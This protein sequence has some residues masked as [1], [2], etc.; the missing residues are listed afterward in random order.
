MNLFVLVWSYLRAKPLNTALNT[1]LL[2]LGIAVVTVLILFGNQLRQRVDANV[3]GIDL[4]VGA[5][6]SPLQLILCSIFH[7]DFP[8]GNIKLHEADQLA[9]HRLVKQAIPLALGD[10][11]QGY[12]VVGTT[13]AY[14]T[15][16]GAELATGRWWQK[17]LELVAGANVAAFANVRVGDLLMSQH[18]LGDGGHAHDAHKI[19]CTGI[20]KKTNSVL[21]NLLFTNIGTVWAVHEPHETHDEHHLPDSIPNPSV[22][23][24]GVSAADSTREITSL[25]IE[26]RNPL[27]AIQLPRLINTQ[28]N[29]QAAS[30]AFETARL[31]SLLGVGADVLLGFAYVI[32]FISALSLFIALYNSLRERQYD[33]AV[34]RSMG[35][36]RTKLFVSVVAEGMA[37]TLAGSLLG[38]GLGHAAVYG[39]TQAVPQSAQTGF[40]AWVIYAEEGWL[41]AASL[42][43]GFVCSLLPAIQA[44]RT[45]I[46]R[47]LAG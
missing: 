6:G 22:L 31:F 42:L 15:L 13:A 17:D 23:V 25:L 36:S 38:M 2:A 40:T 5:K 16:Y 10:S 39:F 1:L 41:L 27:A 9:R 3:R 19:L 8:T 44:Y 26:F 33:L 14:T 24:P 43:L 29:M 12:R 28:T 32:I 47:V 4:V 34:M 45:N 18:G 20:L 21:D 11:Y 46:H 37:L 30:P 35:A 7:I